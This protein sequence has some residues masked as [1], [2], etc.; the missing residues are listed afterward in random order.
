MKIE[1]NI[2]NRLTSLTTLFLSNY[3]HFKAIY[4]RFSNLINIKVV[5]FD[6]CKINKKI[7][8]LDVMA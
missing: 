8:I 2:W 6:E 1:S 3:L 7:F 5:Y 4:N